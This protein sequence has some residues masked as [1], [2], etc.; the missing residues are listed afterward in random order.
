M[1]AGLHVST[2]GGYREAAR[3]AAACGAQAYQYFP[4]NPRSLSVKPFD[5]AEA[6]RCA[7]FCSEHGLASIA[8]SPYPTNIASEDADHR[9]RTVLSLLNDLEIAEACGSLGVVVHFGVYKGPDPLEGY[10]NAVVTLSAITQ[11]WSGRAKLLIEN[12]A[13]DHTFMGTTMEELAQIRGLCAGADKIGFCL[14]TC[15]LFASGVWDGS[16]DAPWMDKAAELGVIDHLAAV[17]LN[18]SVFPSGEKRDRHAI[19]G[20]GFIGKPGLAWLLRHP[21]LAAVPFILETPSGNDG[22]HKGQLDLIR[23]LGG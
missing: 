4:K 7:E 1:R 9:A 12:Q 19:L 21:L 22:S 11:Q 18:D 16:P 17:H 6:E 5:R 20:E 3:R 10:R 14:D 15:H 2:R 8:H 23:Q 13:G